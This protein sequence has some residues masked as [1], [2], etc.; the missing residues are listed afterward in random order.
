MRFEIITAVT[1][2]IIR[3]MGVTPFSRVEICGSFSFLLWK[4]FRYY[5]E[6]NIILLR[7]VNVALGFMVRGL[8][9]PPSLVRGGGGISNSTF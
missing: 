7:H 3:L 1:M 8:H 9:V 5:C 2:Q 4:I 6:E